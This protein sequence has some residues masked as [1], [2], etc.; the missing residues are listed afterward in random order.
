MEWIT[1]CVEV[2]KRN[3]SE[4]TW[5]LLINQLR[6]L[7]ANAVHVIIVQRP[8]TFLIFD[9]YITHKLVLLRVVLLLISLSKKS[10]TLLMLIRAIRVDEVVKTI[11]AVKIKR[12]QRLLVY[13]FFFEWTGLAIVSYNSII[14]NADITPLKTKK[15]VKKEIG[16]LQEFCNERSLNRVFYDL[17]DC[18]QIWRWRRQRYWK[19]V[20]SSGW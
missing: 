12:M 15:G 20:K 10:F 6:I 17:K 14:T 1:Y 9:V 18:F 13:S 19:R 2:K 3:K 4:Y 11:R 5:I 7:S 16:H 8:W